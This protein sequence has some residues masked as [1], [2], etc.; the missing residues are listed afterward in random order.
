[1]APGWSLLEWSLAVI[2]SLASYKMIDITKVIRFIA[3]DIRCKNIYLI[4][5]IFDPGARAIK[6]FT[7]IILA[8]S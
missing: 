8:Y 2:N 3:Q 5:N 6:L 1:M 4:K 7:A